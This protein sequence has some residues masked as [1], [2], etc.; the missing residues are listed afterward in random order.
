MAPEPD[1]D[2]AEE[3]SSQEQRLLGLINQELQE[4]LEFG[5]NTGAVPGIPLQAVCI[6]SHLSSV[7]VLTTSSHLI[8]TTTVL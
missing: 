7:T 5:E 4:I 8:T 3:D 2:E 1:R 6:N